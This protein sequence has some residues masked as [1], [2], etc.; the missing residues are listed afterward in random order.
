VADPAANGGPTETA[1]LPPGSPAIDAGSPAGAPPTDQRG[2]PRVG[3]VDVGAYE[4][5]PDLIFR[6][7]FEP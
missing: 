3:A 6:S 7:G 4:R 5:Q 1:A 2:A